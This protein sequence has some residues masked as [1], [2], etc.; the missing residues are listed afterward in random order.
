MTTDKGRY[1]WIN[2]GDDVQR[3]TKRH[4]VWRCQLCEGPDSNS[5][6]ASIQTADDMDYD[7]PD[8]PFRYE[9]PALAALDQKARDHMGAI[10]PGLASR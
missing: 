8:F 4:W 3:R 1:P 2:D 10:H 5:N 6:S 9:T 7:H